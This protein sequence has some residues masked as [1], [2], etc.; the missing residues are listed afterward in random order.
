M[1]L[2]RLVLLLVAALGMAACNLSPGYDLPSAEGKNDGE[3]EVD[4]G[5]DGDESRPGACA[6]GGAGG[7]GG[8]CSA[9]ETAGE[10]PSN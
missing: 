4:L 5:G 2:S 7:E 6:P 1:K 3:T 9:E 10:T 8:A